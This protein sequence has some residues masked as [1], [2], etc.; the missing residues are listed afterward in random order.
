MYVYIWACMYTLCTTFL[1]VKVINDVYSFV[2]QGGKKIPWHYMPIT[3][4]YKH[5]TTT[6]Y[7]GKFTWKLDYYLTNMTNYQE[8]ILVTDNKKEDFY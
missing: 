6:A 7:L 5:L 8:N 4:T 2:F 1:V 3:T